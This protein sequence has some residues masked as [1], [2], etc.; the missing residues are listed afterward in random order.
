MSSEDASPGPLTQSLNRPLPEFG[1]AAFAAQPIALV[2]Q[3]HATQFAQLLPLF[4]GIRS[5]SARG[6]KASALCAEI[7]ILLLKAAIEPVPPAEMKKGFYTFYFIVH[8][9]GGRLNEAPVSGFE[10]HVGSKS[11]M[12]ITYPEGTIQKT[13][14]YEKDSLFVFSAFKPM[15]F[16]WFLH[17][18]SKERQNSDECCWKSVA[19]VIPREPEDMQILNPH[20][21]QEAAFRLIGLPHKNGLVGRGNIPT[22]GTV[23]IM[24][25]VHN[26][27]E[28]AMTGFGYYEKLKMSAIKELWTHNISKEKEFL[29]KLLKGG[30]IQ[31]LTNGI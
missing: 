5:T 3:D 26:C 19:R 31:D 16:K 14:R 22:L 13:D 21:I 20:F 12:R 25:A 1:R 10:K 4:A 28:M 15:D 9:K 24:M 17:M 11:T 18:V 7:T 27:D 23:A 30:V 29:W 2:C 6:E 8:K